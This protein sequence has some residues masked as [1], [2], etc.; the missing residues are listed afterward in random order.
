MS[1]LKRGI[2][3][4]VSCSKWATVGEQAQ[5][6]DPEELFAIDVRRVLQQWLFFQY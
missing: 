2:P 4:P 5:Y 3:F 1:R 6:E